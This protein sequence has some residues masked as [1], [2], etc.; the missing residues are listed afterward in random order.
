MPEMTMARGGRRR[1][2]GGGGTVGHTQSMP[3]QTLS[4]EMVSLALH[5]HVASQAA[6]IRMASSHQD[7]ACEVSILRMCLGRLYAFCLALLD[8]PVADL[9]S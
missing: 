1:G 9:C 4:S 5:W 2:G 6:I 3:F 7:H 8:K